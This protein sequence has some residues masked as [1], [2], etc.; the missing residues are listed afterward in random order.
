MTLMGS[1]WNMYVY[2]RMDEQL[3]ARG[4]HVEERAVYITTPPFLF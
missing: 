2:P 3:I 1:T 4:R